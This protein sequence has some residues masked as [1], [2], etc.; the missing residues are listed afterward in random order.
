MS[1]ANPDSGP[2]PDPT[3]GPAFVTPIGAHPESRLSR[4]SPSGCD[5]DHRSCV[6]VPPLFG[7]AVAQAVSKDLTR[8]AGAGGMSAMHRSRI[9][10]GGDKD[11]GRHA[12]R[13]LGGQRGL[14]ILDPT[15]GRLAQPRSMS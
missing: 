3:E 15:Y 9:R 4:G 1:P 6:T 13:L 11:I 10:P 14:L 12:R 8:D 5:E 7:T 2:S